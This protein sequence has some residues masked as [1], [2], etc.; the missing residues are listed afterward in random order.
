MRKRES[1]R[2]PN[3]VK[4]YSKIMTAKQWFNSSFMVNLSLIRTT[5]ATWIS[6]Y[7]HDHEQLI[8]GCTT[9]ANTST[10]VSLKNYQLSISK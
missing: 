1:Q 5:S 9:Q 7:L 10:S 4:N 6:G 2:D 8:N 3:L